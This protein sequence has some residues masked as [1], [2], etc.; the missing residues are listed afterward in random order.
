M[1][2]KK[3][4][5]KSIEQQLWEIDIN[6][7]LVRKQRKFKNLTETIKEIFKIVILATSSVIFISTAI[8]LLTCFIYYLR[9]KG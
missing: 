7:Y 4:E 5:E 3:I 2:R 1:E 6:T 9:E 8:F